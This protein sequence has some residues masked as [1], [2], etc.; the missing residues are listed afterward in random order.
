MC[1]FKSELTVAPVCTWI[2]NDMRKSRFQYFMMYEF[3]RYTFYS[4]VKNNN[5]IPID[6]EGPE[7]SQR[8]SQTFVSLISQALYRK[9]G[10]RHK[11]YYV[12]YKSLYLEQ[13]I[14][15]TD[16]LN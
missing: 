4:N 12:H 7:K 5:L 15:F 9:E 10:T 11:T 3:C 1:F 6:K 8:M 2:S 13:N 16:N 14:N